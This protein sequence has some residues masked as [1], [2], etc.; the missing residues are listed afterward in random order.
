MGK[1]RIPNEIIRKPGKLTPEERAVIE[2]HTVIGEE[3]LQ[4]VGGLL[5]EVGAIVRSC[6]ERW[7]GAGYP[8]RLAGE[9]IPLIARIICCTDAF[10]AMTTTRSYRAARSYAEAAGEIERCAGTQFDPDVVRALLAVLGDVG[11]Q[12]GSSLDRVDASVLTR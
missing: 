8:D 11:P 10:S 3:L 12:A 5:G 6:H 7:D 4:K 1:I 2:T 9:W